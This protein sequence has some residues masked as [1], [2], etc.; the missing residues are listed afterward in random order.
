MEQG[1]V[2]RGR[3]AVSS[4]TKDAARCQWPLDLCVLH[5]ERAMW[6]GTC[7]AKPTI[8]LRIFFF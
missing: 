3:P 6:P 2:T 8:I 5:T 4:R 7:K 1:R